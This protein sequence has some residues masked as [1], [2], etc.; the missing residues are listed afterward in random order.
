M[1]IPRRGEHAQGQ[2]ERWIAVQWASQLREQ[3]R[4]TRPSHLECVISFGR[5]QTRI[6]QP[7]LSPETRDTSDESRWN[8]SGH[9]A[10]TE[11]LLLWTGRRTQWRDLLAPPCPPRQLKRKSSEYYSA[12]CGN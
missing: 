9:T 2:H 11:E 7:R 5:V 1:T 12:G 3:H 6:R 8:R 4:S 10:H